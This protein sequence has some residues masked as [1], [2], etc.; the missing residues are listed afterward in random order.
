MSTLHKFLA[1]CEKQLGAYAA[2]LPADFR[3]AAGELAQDLS[4]EEL[5]AWAEE[6][7]ALAAHSLRSWEA[8]AEY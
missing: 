1:E 2:S 8:A 6:G 4:E 7:L 5:R 3:S